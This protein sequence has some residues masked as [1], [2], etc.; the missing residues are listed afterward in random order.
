MK[1]LTKIFALVA[2]LM[3]AVFA[4]VGC[5][6]ADSKLKL[7]TGGSS[8][9]YYAYGNVL[10]SIA[11]NDAGVKVNA[12]SSGASKANILQISNDQA[13]LAIVQND[14][15]FY[16]YTGTDL[17]EAQ[18]EQK[19]FRIVG[20]LYSE[21]CQIVARAGIN[22]IE[23]LKGKRVSVGDARSGVEFNAKQILGAYDISFGDIQKQNLSFGDSADAIKDGT[24][25]AF[26]CTAGAPTT[27]IVELAT[28]HNINLLSVDEAHIA[29]LQD[30]YDF[31]KP[32]TVPAGT[33]TGINTDTLMVT[34]KATLIADKDVSEDKIYN[35]VK[36]LFAKDHT[37]SHA[38]FEE[39]NVADFFDACEESTVPFHAG[40]LKYYNEHK[41]N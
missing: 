35:I 24:L 4:F 22:S 1:K 36:A 20:Y 16:A 28:T 5:G 31:Y 19:D 39:L 41:A 2:S 14:V 8:G 33:Y 12:V 32:Y 18:G 34:V 15:A 13:D 40:A 11:T 3:I 38:K 29:E 23:D 25:D 6:G 26:F 30:T 17:F 21:V 7:A 10:A 9:T 37:A 27:A